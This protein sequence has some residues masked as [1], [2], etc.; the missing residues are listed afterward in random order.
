MNQTRAEEITMRED[1]GNINLETGTVPYNGNLIP[2]A[3]SGSLTFVTELRSSI[4]KPECGILDVI[5]RTVDLKLSVNI[6]NCQFF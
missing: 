2:V 6:K 1:Y 3:V 4:S 5:L